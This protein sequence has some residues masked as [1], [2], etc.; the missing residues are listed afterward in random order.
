MEA[1]PVLSHAFRQEYYP[2]HAEDQFKVVSLASPIAVPF[3]SFKT[4]L[5]TQ[6]QTALEPDVLD[7]KYYVKGV[8][9]VA[10][11]SVKG[12]TE[13]ALLVSYSTG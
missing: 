11:I 6:E 3:G 2:G 13:R 10:E 4:A 8:G 1:T 7:H 9:E 5:L 12:P